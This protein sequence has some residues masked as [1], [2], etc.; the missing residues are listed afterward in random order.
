VLAGGVAG[1]IVLAR[2]VRVESRAP[3]MAAL[4]VVTGTAVAALTAV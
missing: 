4:C 1:A 2:R 3:A